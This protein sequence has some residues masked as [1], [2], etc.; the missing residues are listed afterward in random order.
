[1]IGLWSA[2][3]GVTRYEAV[4]AV[5][6]KVLWLSLGPLAVLAALLAVTSPTVIGQDDPVARIGTA[7]LAINLCYT[8]GIGVAL[9]DRLVQQYRAGLA[10]LLNATPG[11]QAA[12]LV[13]ALLGPLG[14]AV[15]PA[16]VLLV[17]LGVV[18]GIGHGSP[19]PVGAAVVGLAA[20]LMPAALVITTLATLLG[21]V[22]PQTVARVVVVVLWF[23]STALSPSLFPGVP[24]PTG[25]VLSPLGGYLAV[26][27]LHVDPS[28][29][30]RGTSSTLRPIAGFATATISVALLLGLAILFFGAARVVAA[31]R[32]S[33]EFR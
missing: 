33:K 16:A 28:W 23:W 7:T 30:N 25:T 20:V 31:R 11:G 9:T 2:T 32:V 24:T 29:A 8:A 1:M 18:L 15:V 22:L 26:A 5:R 14:V 10:D 6:R 27:A 3:L 13:G 19:A 17:L 21:L 4:M 12:C